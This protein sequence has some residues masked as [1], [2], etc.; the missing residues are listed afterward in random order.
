MYKDD[1]II[2]LRGKRVKDE[3]VEFRIGRGTTIVDEAG[4]KVEKDNEASLI[5]VAEE[6]NL[7]PNDKVRIKF[8]KF[9]NLIATH[10]Y[11]DI[12]EKHSDEDVIISTD[13][14]ADIANAHDEEEPQSGHKVPL[15][16]VVGI[17]L[18]IALTYIL[19]KM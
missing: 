7:R 1:D 16:F 8:D 13:L 3:N 10:A 15:I 17:V 11:E 18:G 14:L 9:V 4:D 12:V 2:D 6:A 19:F 5:S